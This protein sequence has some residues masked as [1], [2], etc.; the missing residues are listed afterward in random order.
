MSEIKKIL[1]TAG[2]T[3][4][5]VFPAIAVA[6][7]IRRENPNVELAFVGASHGN[8]ANWIKNAGYRFILLDV[9]FIKGASFGRKVKN[10]FSLP[11]CA[12][13][14]LEILKTEAPDL[15][16]GAGGYVSGPLVAMATM[17]HIKTAIMEQNAIPGLTNRIL[18]KFVDKIYISFE[19]T[20]KLPQKKLIYMGNPVR[21]MSVDQNEEGSEL[22]WQISCLNQPLQEQPVHI[23]IIGGSQGA[24][25]LNTDIPIALSALPESL[26]ARIA[27]YHQTG[28]NKFDETKSA[29]EKAGVT[30]KLSEF[31]DHMGAAYHWADLVI[32]RAGATSIAEIKAASKP[33]ILVPFPFA[34][35]NHQEKNADAMVAIG[36]S[37]KVLNDNVAS[38]IPDV[39]TDFMAHPEKLSDMAQAAFNDAKPNA[40]RD[41]ARDCLSFCGAERQS[42]TA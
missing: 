1:L 25:K 28:K 15:V 29:Y 19:N 38:Q 24:M 42:T 6:D 3:G 39:L 35:H 40:A 2:G 30:A 41:I 33:S 20:S 12:N 21:S 26:R 10:L 5:H 22:D 9:D 23:L 34:A 16:I 8:E 27:V 7:A 36:A 32:C 14:A 4:G 37:V 17:K 13:R 31:I 18:S 11:K